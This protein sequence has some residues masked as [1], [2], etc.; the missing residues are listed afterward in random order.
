M[1]IIISII[2]IIIIIIIIN[3]RCLEWYNKEPDPE[4][5]EDLP[6]CP[7]DEMA[8]RY[9]PDFN[10][11][12]NGI[13]RKTYELTFPAGEHYGQRCVYRSF[14]F[15]LSYSLVVGSDNRGSAQFYHPS[16]RDE[17]RQ[18]DQDPYNWCCASTTDDSR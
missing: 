15:G 13:F 3:S 14:F 1:L 18:Y 6:Q 12:S 16:M 5:A 9:N 8:A 10:L 17:H 4:W 11:I 2:T 7:C